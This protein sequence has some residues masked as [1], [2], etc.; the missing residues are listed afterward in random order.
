MLPVLDL[1][2][3]TNDCLTNGGTVRGYVRVKS[4]EQPLLKQQRR[5]RRRL[6]QLRRWPGHKENI[7][8]QNKRASKPTG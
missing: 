1:L 2:Q 8:T 4:G 7:S 6:Y 5:R 3:L